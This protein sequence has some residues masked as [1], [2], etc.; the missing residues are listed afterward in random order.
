MG[1]R[2]ESFSYEPLKVTRGQLML[3][4]M[5]LLMNNIYDLNDKG[6][7]VVVKAAKHEWR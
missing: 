7:V 6:D 5:A 1:T 3:R 4:N 2:K